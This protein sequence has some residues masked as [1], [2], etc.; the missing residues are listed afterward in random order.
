[1]SMT[2]R[3]AEALRKEASA[4]RYMG[5]GP[6][7]YAVRQEPLSVFT[8]LSGH[9][10]IP[11]IAPS[12][13]RIAISSDEESGRE[14]YQMLVTQ[15]CAKAAILAMREPTAWMVAAGRREM[16]IEF[17]VR[18]R[19]GGVVEVTPRLAT[20]ECADPANVFRAMIDV[21]AK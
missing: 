5:F 10:P 8:G 2:E 14:H 9:G 4:W 1:M 13:E 6:I 7:W 16:P 12:I 18:Q 3:V 11:D 21:A 20:S 17:D 15:R 19:H